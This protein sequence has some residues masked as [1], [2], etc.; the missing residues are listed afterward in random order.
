MVLDQETK[1]FIVNTAH[2]SYQSFTEQID[3]AFKPIFQGFDDM[4]QRFESI[5]NRL[6]T[7]DGILNNINENTKVLPQI[8][9]ILEQNQEQKNINSQLTS[10]KYANNLGN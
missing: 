4:D 8:L 3:E 7:I 9:T 5:E 10:I 2:V 1:D 6:K